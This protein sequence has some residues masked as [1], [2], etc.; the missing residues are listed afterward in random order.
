M[1]RYRV[2]NAVFAFGAVGFVVTTLWNWL[3]R[4]AFGGHLIGVWLAIGLFVVARLLVGGRRRGDRC[5]GGHWRR[6]IAARRDDMSDEERAR[7]GERSG[8][9]RCGPRIDM[10]GGRPA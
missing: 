6:R 10:A 9:S 1:N 7:F 3:A 4:A 8:R 5:P 2:W